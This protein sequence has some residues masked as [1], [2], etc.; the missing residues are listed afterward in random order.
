MTITTPSGGGDNCGHI[1][2]KCH[3]A[4]AEKLYKSTVSEMAISYFKVNSADG[5]GVP[6]SVVAVANQTP[7]DI[8]EMYL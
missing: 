4:Y 1:V 2:V 7:K 6:S 8:Y 5:A 3:R